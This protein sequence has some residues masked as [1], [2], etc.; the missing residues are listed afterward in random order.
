MAFRPGHGRMCLNC[1]VLNVIPLFE[2]KCEIKTHLN[3]VIMIPLSFKLRFLEVPHVGKSFFISLWCVILD[4]KIP[5]GKKSR[6]NWLDYMFSFT[7]T[8][9]NHT[10]MQYYI[11]QLYLHVLVDDGHVCERALSA[12]V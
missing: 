9:E 10:N 3:A 11:V 5:L 4:G 7:N 1:N 2:G 12:D 6:S 8:N